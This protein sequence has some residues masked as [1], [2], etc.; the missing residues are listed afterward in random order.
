MSVQRSS[1]STTCFF[2]YRVSPVTSWVSSHKL[3]YLPI[4]KHVAHGLHC[5][6]G[7]DYRFLVMDC[8]GEDVEK[9]FNQAGRRFG[10]KTVCHLALRIVSPL[11]HDTATPI[12][13]TPIPVCLLTLGAH[14]QRGL[15]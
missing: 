3:A 8:F 14:A 7:L 6:A 2:A 1:E 15:R 11:L 10:S 4:P 9:K 12:Y 13:S 5:H